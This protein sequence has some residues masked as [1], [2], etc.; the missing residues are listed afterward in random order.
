VTVRSASPDWPAA[1]AILG[2]LRLLTRHGTTQPAND[3]TAH[4]PLMP[5]VK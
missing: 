4:A 5:H 1:E 3:E 2:S